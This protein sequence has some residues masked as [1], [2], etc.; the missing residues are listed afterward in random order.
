MADEDIVN[1]YF[2]VLF[3]LLILIVNYFVIFRRSTTC[4]IYL[5]FNIS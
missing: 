5:S 1:V 2:L 3:S 4:I